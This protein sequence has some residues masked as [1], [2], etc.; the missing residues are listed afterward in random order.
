MERDQA[1]HAGIEML[2]VP[3]ALALIDGLNG[4]LDIATPG[5]TWTAK[6]DSRFNR[7]YRG[8]LLRLRVRIAAMRT[9]IFSQLGASLPPTRCLAQKNPA[10][11]RVSWVSG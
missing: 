5:T 10:R 3:A 8:N 9:A 7:L 6:G 1:H 2:Q 11:G 4:Y